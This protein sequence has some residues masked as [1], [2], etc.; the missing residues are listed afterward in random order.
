M[1]AIYR[2]VALLS[3]FAILASA[4]VT[5]KATNLPNKQTAYSTS[6]TY[7]IGDIVTYGGSG[8]IAKVDNFSSQTPVQGSTYWDA[9][10]LPQVQ[11]SGGTAIPQTYITNYTALGDSITCG[12]TL[13]DANC[14]FGSTSTT[15]SASAFPELIGA[16]LD[17]PVTNLGVSR[18]EACDQWPHEIYLRSILAHREGHQLFT[19]LIGTNDADAGSNQ[20]DFQLCHQAILARLLT[21]AETTV[22]PGSSA[23][24]GSGSWSAAADSSNTAFSFSGAYASGSGTLTASIITYGSPIYVW[25]TIT[26]TSSGT[27]SL[28][29]DG[30]SEGSFSSQAPATITTPN[31]VTTSVALARITGIAAGAHTVVASTSTGNVVIQGIGTLPS[32]KY[33]GYPLVLSG[34]IPNQCWGC[35]GDTTAAVVAQYESYV[36][37]DEALFLTDGAQGLRHVP[38]T[39]YMLGTAAETNDGLHP[40]ATIGHPEMESAFLQVAQTQPSLVTTIT[41][42]NTAI[43]QLKASGG[44]TGGTTPS[45]PV[46]NGL[47]EYWPMTDGSGTTAAN[48]VNASNLL[49]LGAGISWANETG[50]ASSKAALFS[51][52]SGTNARAIAAQVDAN[53]QFDGTSPFTLSLWVYTSTPNSAMA[54]LSNDKINFFTN[55]EK[56][57]F[58]LASGVMAGDPGVSGGEIQIGTQS[59]LAANTPSNVVV[60][61]DGSGKAAG[62]HIYLNNSA[63]VLYGSDSDSFTATTNSTTPWQVGNFSSAEGDFPF[64]GPISGVALYNRVLSS[65]DMSTI[66]AAGA[67]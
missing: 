18:D 65:S 7:Y 47:V 52:Q 11:S 29:V 57:T 37:A 46:T 48:D 67:P 6:V 58:R 12:Y 42:L 60:T 54:F 44:T 17:V 49:T 36:A 19:E 66:V 8:W 20:T 62:V 31:G 45:A 30:N 64:N 61:Y 41:A 13:S 27:F 1:K 63:L 59:G 32:N 55:G 16:F 5:R 43:T 21:P 10:S 28:T 15:P 3:V 51:G 33:Y 24:T 23:L 39:L 50:F 2:L 4:Q 25:Y 38:D 14:P 35:G 34:A 53:S 56:I 9:F 26:N 22:L 40:N